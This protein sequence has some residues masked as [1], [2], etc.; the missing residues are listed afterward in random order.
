[1][2][3]TY[4]NKPNVI[5]EVY[6]EPINSSWTNDIKPYAEQVIDAIRSIDPDN[7]IIVGTRFYSAYVN[8]AADNPINKKILPIPYIFMQHNIKMIIEKDADMHYL[9]G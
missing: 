5:Y 7:L 4:G 3:Q 6:N 1:M 2:A 8:E 9:K